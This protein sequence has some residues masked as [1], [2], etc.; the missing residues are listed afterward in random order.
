MVVGRDENQTCH[1]IR[2]M[3]TNFLKYCSS[4]LAWRRMKLW[5]TVLTRKTLIVLSHPT[6]IIYLE[7]VINRQTSLENGY[8]ETWLQ[9]NVRWVKILRFTY[10]Y[11]FLFITTYVNDAT[12]SISSSETNR[13][14]KS[15]FATPLT[16]H[17]SYNC[18]GDDWKFWPLLVKRSPIITR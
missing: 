10:N 2:T 17:L 14:L 5:S 4:P 15:K 18:K 12:S 13:G 7:Q 3:K 1:P 6:D 11:L 8:K 9:S 16:I